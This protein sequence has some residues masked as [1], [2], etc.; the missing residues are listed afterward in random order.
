MAGGL[1]DA[2]MDAAAE[3][4]VESGAM[5][6]PVLDDQHRVAGV[7]GLDDVL[8]AYQ[9]ALESNY[10]HFARVTSGATLIEEDVHG[11][12]RIAGKPSRSR[13]PPTTLILSIRRKDQL[14]FPRAD[15]ILEP[16]DH[17]TI[18]VDP[19]DV[20]SVRTALGGEAGGSDVPPEDTQPLI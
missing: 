16:D 8:H 17:V 15:T 9:T 11:S 7:L 18:L 10:R 3:A 19:A 1:V 4:I 5:W 14:I 13:P 20:P 6:V 2:T 12:S